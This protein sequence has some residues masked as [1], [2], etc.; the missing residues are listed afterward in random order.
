[1]PE[2]RDE[3]A[4]ILSR[5][6]IDP[7]DESKLWECHGVLVL[8]HRAYEMIARIEQ[9]RWEAP[10]ILEA[11]TVGGE[12]SVAILA[13]AQSRD[14]I[15]EWSIGEASLANYQVSGRQQ[16]YPYAMAEKRARDRVIA[17]LVGLSEYVYSEEEAEEFR[18]AQPNRASERDSAPPPAIA[19]PPADDGI[20]KS[21]AEWEIWEHALTAKIDECKAPGDL[22]R[23]WHQN[24]QA[25]ETAKEKYG[26]FYESLAARFTKRRVALEG[27]SG[28]T[29]IQ[30]RGGKNEV[31][32]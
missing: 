15:Y 31:R 30:G 32:S 11:C 14:G 13:A 20:P 16:A 18:E 29:G 12:M 19:S 25:L 1:M 7:N 6:D 9:I 2:I 4:E 23:L 8:Y 10:K 17:K 21:G 5:Y 22:R 26:V 28:S 3:L 27:T 24:E